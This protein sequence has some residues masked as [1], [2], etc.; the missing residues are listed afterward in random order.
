V[1]G[2]AE[3]W[4]A[5]DYLSANPSGP[6][7]LTLEQLVRVDDESYALCAEALAAFDRHSSLSSIATPVLA[8]SGEYD[9]V[10]TPASMAALAQALPAASSI[11]LAGASHLSVLEQPAEATELLA[12]FLGAVATAPSAYDRGMRVRRSVLGD[13]HVDAA[14]AAITP[15]TAAFQDFITRSAWGDIWARPGLSR[16]ERSIATLAVLVADSHEHEL[17][18]HIRAAIRNGM[19]RAEIGEVIMHTALYAGL[20]PANR[21]LAIMRETFIALDQ[22][23][24]PTP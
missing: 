14:T 13:A 22:D 1:I 5:P 10:T 3:R 15:E 17:R 7:A 18:M 20:P 8:V 23:G 24:T 16:R 6:A 9:Q 12:E 11:D 21:G 2:S 4:F 19:S